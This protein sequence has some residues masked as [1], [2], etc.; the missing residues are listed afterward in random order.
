MNQ[1]M[2]MYSKNI[3]VYKGEF[4]NGMMNGHGV[5]T[6]NNGISYKVIYI[7]KGKL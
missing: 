7:I 2:V 4:K 5:K 6:Y 3:Q 1:I